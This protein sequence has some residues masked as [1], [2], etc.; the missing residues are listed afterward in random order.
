MCGKRN[1]ARPL[2]KSCSLSRVG[3][4]ALRARDWQALFVTHRAAWCEARLTLFGHALMEKLCTPRPAITAHVWLL[5]PSADAQASLLAELTPERLAR[6]PHFPLP[7]LGVPGWW[8]ANDD[9]TFYADASVFCPPNAG[10]PIGH[11]DTRG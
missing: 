7:V 3:T 8:P 6:R 10:A 2:K 11:G 9:P 4:P 1:Q 5:P